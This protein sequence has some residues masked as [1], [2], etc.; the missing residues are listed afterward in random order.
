MPKDT[1][2]QSAPPEK[3]RRVLRAEFTRFFTRMRTPEPG[4]PAISGQQFVDALADSLVEMAR[5]DNQAGVAYLQTL[6]H[7]LQDRV[8][9]ELNPKA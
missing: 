3:V 8:N 5:T 4:W 6:V 2:P 1:T 7:E 9:T